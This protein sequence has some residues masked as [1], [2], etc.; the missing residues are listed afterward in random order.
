MT[1]P[2]NRD[3]I[4]CFFQGTCCVGTHP[5]QLSSDTSNC[6]VSK[7]NF[8]NNTNEMGYFY[9]YYKNV[10]TVIKDSVPSNTVHSG[11][12]NWIYAAETGSCV[13]ICCS[14]LLSFD[15]IPEDTRVI[16]TNIK[17]TS[18]IS[19]HRPFI[20]H[21]LIKECN[22]ASRLFSLLIFLPLNANIV[23]FL[24]ILCLI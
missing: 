21:P 8:I 23:V 22:Q 4:N 14:F 19:T 9:L 1:T 12:L 10:K 16:L 18:C 20:N 3:D 7:Y 11:P 6:I 15:S 2:V 5:I 13:E 24:L 17:C